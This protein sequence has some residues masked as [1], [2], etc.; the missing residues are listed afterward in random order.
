[1]ETNNIFNFDI[2]AEDLTEIFNNIEHNLSLLDEEFNVLWANKAYIERLGKTYDKVIG[3]KCYSLWHHRDKVCENCPCDEAL[4]TNRVET[5]ERI[6]AEGRYYLL[7]AIPLKYSKNK[8]L[9]FEIGK[10]ITETKIAKEKYREAIES[11]AINSILT[12]FTHQLTN[13]L[14]GIYGF[15]QLLEKNIKEEKMQKYLYNLIIASEKG[16][17][18]V[19]A[20]KKL[21]S[22]ISNEAIFNLNYL[23][24][25]LKN[26]IKEIL[27]DDIILETSLSEI[28]QLIKGDPL[29][30]RELIIELI[31]NAKNFIQGKGVVSISTEKVNSKV[32]LKIQDSGQGMD[33]ETL[34]HCFDPL[35]STDPK[36]FGLGLTIVKGIVEAHNGYIEIKS[37]KDSGTTVNIYF[38]S[39]T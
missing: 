9:I 14:T 38:P 30:I 27:G 7:T 10:E 13:I 31:K 18:F 17:K 5:N 26:T 25:S 22:S 35:F 39:V 4:K 8:K 23:L 15:A 19:N 21:K 37:K 6:S 16:L 32:L 34:K 2:N 28:P 20:L 3:K 29:Q 24:I 12:N 1:M 33:E 36:K 11:Q